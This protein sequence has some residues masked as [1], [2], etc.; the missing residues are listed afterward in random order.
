LTT[1]STKRDK[2]K[3]FHKSHNSSSISPKFIRSNIKRK[4]A[5]SHQPKMRV[6][7]KMRNNKRRR[8]KPKRGKSKGNPKSSK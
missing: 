3:Q 4:Q 7:R 6:K 8:G 2:E 1:S 5:R